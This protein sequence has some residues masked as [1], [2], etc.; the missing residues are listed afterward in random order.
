MSSPSSPPGHVRV[1]LT[2]TWLPQ[3]VRCWVDGHE[4]FSH[5]HQGATVPVVPGDHEVTCEAQGAGGFGR[6]SLRVR[7]APGRTVTVYYAAPLS[8]VSQ[9]SI[10]LT[11]Q[12]RRA[13]L[14]GR[15]ILVSVA[16]VVVLLLCCGVIGTVAQWLG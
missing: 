11:P 4:V 6:A 1:V 9:G 14:D 5:E 7:V 2:P 10:G 8:H 16:G 13:S 3:P 15:Q 12:S